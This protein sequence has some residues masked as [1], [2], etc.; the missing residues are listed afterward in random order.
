MK[1]KMCI[2]LFSIL[3]VAGCVPSLHQLW[4]DKT[5]VYDETIVGSFKEGGNV[6]GQTHLNHGF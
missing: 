5:L 4:T 1:V 6:S 2:A 3:F